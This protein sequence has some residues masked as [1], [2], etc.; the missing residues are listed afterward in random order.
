MSFVKLIVLHFIVCVNR[1]RKDIVVLLKL[2]R[3]NTVVKTRKNKR[4]DDDG[5]L[6]RAENNVNVILCSCL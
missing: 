2:S 4:R 6:Q 5:K 1:E 3:G